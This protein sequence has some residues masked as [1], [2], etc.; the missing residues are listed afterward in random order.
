MQI[1]LGRF[2]VLKT[3]TKAE[4]D[5][6][7]N[8]ENECRLIR[9]ENEELKLKLNNINTKFNKIEEHHNLNLNRVIDQN[10]KSQQMNISN[11]QQVKSNSQLYKRNLQLEETV[12]EL[13]SQ[14]EQLKIS[15]QNRR[16]SH[17]RHDD[18]DDDD[19]DDSS[20]SNESNSDNDD[21]NSNSDDNN[22]NTNN[23]DN[24]LK[25]KLT[26]PKIPPISL[27]PASISTAWSQSQPV[28][29]IID[30][31]YQQQHSRTSLSGYFQ[32]HSPNLINKNSTDNN[33]HGIKNK[34]KRS[35]TLSSAP[36]V[37]TG[38]GLSNSRSNSRESQD[39]RR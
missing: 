37:I 11:Q 39:V 27:F 25:G 31:Q 35:S 32:Q 12:L 9:L 8:S 3:M 29:P 20:L 10:V 33:N 28:S 23:N 6:R 14:I 18:D 4:R 24:I 36:S 19:D 17:S 7:I 30:Q 22:A 13:K 21:N 15:N 5:A 16:R 26:S 1:L 2:Q 34:H 38:L